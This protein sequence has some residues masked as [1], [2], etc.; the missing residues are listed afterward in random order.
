MVSESTKQLANEIQNR[1][2]QDGISYQCLS[3]LLGVAIYAFETECDEKWALKVTSYIKECCVYGI[4][5]GIEVLQLDELYWKTI[6]AE[7]PY[8][9]ESY[10]FYMERKRQPQKRFYEPRQEEYT[11]SAFANSWWK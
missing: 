1:I 4:Q 8:W 7:A 2:S 9:F 11:N 5:N 6:K 3:D 10:L